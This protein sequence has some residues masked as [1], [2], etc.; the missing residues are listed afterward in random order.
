LAT[1][2]EERLTDALDTRVT[3]ATG[4]GRGRITIEFADL[5]DLKRLS[6]LLVNH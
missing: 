6:D 4:G 3:V 5:E 2:V 1:E